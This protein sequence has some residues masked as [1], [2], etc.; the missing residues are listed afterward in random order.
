VFLNNASSQLETSPEE[1][2]LVLEPED[3][4][5]MQELEK[6][7]VGVSEESQCAVTHEG[8]S[9]MTGAGLTCALVIHSLGYLGAIPEC[10][11][12][13]C[14]IFCVLA[15]VVCLDGIVVSLL[16]VE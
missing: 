2:K 13:N 4:H 5:K 3:C 16:N 9:A 12:E 15:A 14:R 11:E 10:N 1:E 8:M 7:D 6:T